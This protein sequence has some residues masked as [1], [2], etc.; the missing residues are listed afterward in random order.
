MSL[1]HS[2]ANTAEAYYVPGRG[3]TKHTWPFATNVLT[4]HMDG[5]TPRQ[6]AVRAMLDMRPL[7]QRMGRGAT[8][9]AGGSEKFHMRYGP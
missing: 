3:R 9:L 1:T 5:Y 2:T 7:L 8:N 4:V 6:T